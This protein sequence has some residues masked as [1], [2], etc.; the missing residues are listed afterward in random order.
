M[1]FFEP[2]LVQGALQDRRAHSAPGVNSS[3]APQHEEEKLSFDEHLGRP[4]SPA[5]WSSA[6]SALP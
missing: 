2:V 1:S 6:C 5:L 3:M 4:I